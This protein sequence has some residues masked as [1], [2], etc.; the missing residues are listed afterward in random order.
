MKITLYY[1]NKKTGHM[2]IEPNNSETAQTFIQVM[3]NT[4]KIGTSFLHGFNRSKVEIV[5]DFLRLCELVKL[6]NE[7]SYDR[8]ILVDMTKDFS[9]Q[10]LFDL[11][12]HFEHLGHRKRSNDP[13]LNLSSYEE[14]INLG[15]EMNGLIHK[16]ESGL[17]GGLY[18]QVLFAKPNIIRIPLNESVIGEA[19]TSYKNEY[20][21]VGFGETG[22]NMKHIF[23]IKDVEVLHRKLVQPQRYILSEIFVS[24]YDECFDYDSYEK[25]CIEN[26]AD[27]YGY[28]YKNP[29]W[30]GKWE[31]GKIVDKTWGHTNQFPLYDSVIY[32]D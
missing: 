17:T 20:I 19:V 5:N 15:C 8:K 11:H 31:I 21:Y 9:L 10:K 29:I 32:E 18:F 4:D 13:T 12:E 22:K 6:I 30:Y 7:S 27:K 14:I 3:A 28:D 2:V 25:W 23:E 16:L 26:N 24:F 1:K